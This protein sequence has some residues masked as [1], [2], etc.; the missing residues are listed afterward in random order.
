MGIKEVAENHMKT[1]ADSCPSCSEPPTLAPGAGK[2]GVPGA[3][4]HV[5]FLFLE[6][7]G[8]GEGHGQEQV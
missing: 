1:L 7:R 8:A 6:P 2:A 5:E 3:R 4:G